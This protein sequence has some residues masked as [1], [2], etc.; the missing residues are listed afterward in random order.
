[1]DRREPVPEAGPASRQ[2][3]RRGFLAQLGGAGAATLAG[4][5]AVPRSAAQEAA[6]SIEP[7][8]GAR[9]SGRRRRNEAFEL[10]QRAALLYLHRPLAS[11]PDNGDERRYDNRLGSFSKC[12]PHNDRGE[13]NP[14]AYRL[15]LRA[16]DSGRRRDLEAIPMGGSVKLANPLGGLAFDLEGFD[17]H[18]LVLPPAPSFASAWEASEMAEVYWQA[19]TRDVPFLEYGSDPLIAEAAADLSRFSDFR[20]PKEGDTV[21][22]ETL[23]RGDTPGDLA[24][25]YLSQFLWKDVPYGMTT[26]VQRYRTAQ[27]GTDFMTSFA[28]CLARQRGIPP[29][30]GTVFDP[31]PRY[32]RSGRD[33]AEWDHRDFTYQGFLNA[34]L[35]LLALGPAALDAANPYLASATQG[36]FVTFGGPNILDLVGRVANAAL[37]ATWF[38]KWMVHRR[39]RP[40]AFGARVHARITGLAPRYAIHSELL[41]SAA[42]AAVFNARGTYL[43]P[44][45]YAEGSPTHPSYPA[46]HAAIAG[47]C[48]TVLKAFFKESF[49]LPN[50]VEA[51]ADG[52]SLMPYTG[53]P[54]TVG[55]ELDKLAAN[56]ALGRDTAG[57][58]W[59]SD[60]IEGLNLGEAVAIGVLRDFRATFAEEFAGFSLTR[61][62][63]S[64]VTV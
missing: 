60:G 15:Y 51:A 52:Q 24:G 55:G 53:R 19:L 20:G 31:V 57:V 25:P 28:D 36:S 64:T 44:M 47:A 2:P 33:L 45:A 63:G 38:Q 35:I 8:S 42:V 17:S 41:H 29:T 11:H 34:A 39:L 62:D 56:V 54:L 18:D 43:L 48:V 32:I 50:P 21:T 23:F 7:A 10:R 40:E 5:A 3:A 37:R 16:L 49:V 26:I 6:I 12:L 61:F 46:G 9:G 14:T 13:V 27:P 59:R 58:H 4:M 30:T 1:M 22:P